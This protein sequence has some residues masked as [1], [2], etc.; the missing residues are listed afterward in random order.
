M[1]FLEN[2][3]TRKKI[4]RAASDPMDKIDPYI[5]IYIYIYIYS[6]AANKTHTNCVSYCF[7]TKH[8]I[9]MLMPNFA[10]KI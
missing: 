3:K 1:R 6:Y 7:G 5:Y 10:I 8:I 4:N 2:P 9:L